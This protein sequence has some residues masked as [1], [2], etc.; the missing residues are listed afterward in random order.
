MGGSTQTL[1]GSTGIRTY[2]FACLARVVDPR[3]RGYPHDNGSQKYPSW[4][5]YRI[6][7]TYSVNYPEWLLCAR[8]RY[9]SDR[10]TDDFPHRALQLYISG[11]VVCT[12]HQGIS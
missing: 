2:A 10:G 7:S 5:L 1:R 11:G 12:I 6:R 9:G 4:R 8:L 3:L